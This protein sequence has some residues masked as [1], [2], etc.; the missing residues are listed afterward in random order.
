MQVLDCRP[1]GL[2]VRHLGPCVIPD[3]HP[4][5]WP[6]GTM[7]F[8]WWTVTLY[9]VLRA[10]CWWL[11][12]L[13]GVWWRRRQVVPQRRGRRQSR[14]RQSRGPA[15]RR[16]SVHQRAPAPPVGPPPAPG[17]QSRPRGCRAAVA[18]V[19][20]RRLP[21]AHDARRQPL[22]LVRE[23]R[24]PPGPAYASQRRGP[25][26]RRRRQRRRKQHRRN[27]RR[28]RSSTDRELRQLR[29]TNLNTKQPQR[30]RLRYSWSR[31]RN[32]VALSD[33]EILFMLSTSR[34]RKSKVVLK[35]MQHTC[36]PTY[37]TI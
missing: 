29:R 23:K 7:V 8:R 33:V 20:H 3:V 34:N 16:W 9:C 5:A 35:R 21:P 6:V 37:K 11:Q 15:D 36:R 32:Y 30:S 1:C 13:H 14:H 24:P 26:R 4:N 27:R 22:Q 2:E 19:R 10:V 18:A 17:N 25:P 28:R 31:K 12:R